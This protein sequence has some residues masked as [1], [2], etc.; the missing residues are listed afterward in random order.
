MS[1]GF[2][3]SIHRRDMAQKTANSNYVD[4]LKR[5]RDRFVALAFCAADALF[6]LD[7]DKKV[8]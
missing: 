1:F 7:G 6:E 5:E 2:R 4:T 8:A 3:T